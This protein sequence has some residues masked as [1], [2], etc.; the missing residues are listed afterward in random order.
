MKRK[1]MSEELN[2]PFSDLYITIMITKYV[3][4]K[5]YK[6]TNPHTHID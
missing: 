3:Y 6:N 4:I 2:E 1:E 5:I